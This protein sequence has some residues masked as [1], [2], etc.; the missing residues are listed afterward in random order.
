M[1]SKTKTT[2]SKR[3]SRAKGRK[4]LDSRRSE[5][6]QELREVVGV[7]SKID[8][9]RVLFGLLFALVSIFLILA[10]ASNCFTGSED[11]AGVECG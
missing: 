2:G 7:Q 8:I 11:Q 1:A 9:A 5:L 10:I 4:T 6:K 3:K